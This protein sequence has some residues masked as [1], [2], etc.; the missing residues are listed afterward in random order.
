MPRKIYPVLLGVAYLLTFVA[1]G[2]GAALL[3]QTLTIQNGHDDF[4]QIN[5]LH[6]V[7]YLALLACL[8]QRQAWLNLLYF[9]GALAVA[10]AN[11]LLGFPL[12]F[13]FPA[14]FISQIP[15]IAVG[16]GFFIQSFRY[17]TKEGMKFQLTIDDLLK[18]VVFVA[19]LAIA[20]KLCLA[21]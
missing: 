2:H 19:A 21:K 5:F 15:L 8:V 13:Y 18:T 3:I 1:G 4:S 7:F 9:S 20:Y 6:A 11:P 14:T 10:I 17:F 12:D 16:L